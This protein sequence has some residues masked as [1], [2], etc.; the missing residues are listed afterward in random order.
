MYDTHTFGFAH[1]AFV[2]QGLLFAIKSLTGIH[3]EGS[4][5]REVF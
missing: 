2:Q 5:D 1:G 4:V 3:C